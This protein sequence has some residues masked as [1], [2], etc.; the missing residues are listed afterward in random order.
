MQFA[1]LHFFVHFLT[2]FVH[3]ALIACVNACIH[4]SGEETYK[5]L[6]LLNFLCPGPLGVEFEQIFQKYLVDQL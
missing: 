2:N 5:I 1:N 3:F 4:I 6:K